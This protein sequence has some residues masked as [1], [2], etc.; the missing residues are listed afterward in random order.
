MAMII[1]IKGSREAPKSARSSMET[2]I[3]SAKEVDSWKTPPFQRPLR[4]NDKVRSMAEALKQNAVEISG[5][6]TLG[7][8]SKDPATWIVDGQHRLEAFKISGLEEIIADVRVCHFDS[9]GEMA[10]EFV[11]LNSSLVKMRPDD[12]LR[13]LESSILALQTIRKQ[14]DFVGYDNIRRANSHSPMLSM[15]ALLRCW[16][17]SAYETPTTSSAGL[18]A[19]QMAETIDALSTQNL[20]VF[21]LTAHSAWGRD[22][23]YFRLWGN[24]NLAMTM[25]MWR[26]FVMDKDRQGNKRYV[27]LTPAQFKQCLMSVSASSDYVDWLQGRNLSERDRSPCYTRLKSIFVKRLSTEGSQVKPKLPAPAWASK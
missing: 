10:S 16:M 2:I 4:I 19:A 3:V 22:P 14:C 9:M 21:L 11:Q 5:I 7:R 15:S 17:A 6:L 1:P 18:S 13:G 24:L 26:R 20:I 23:E 12:V 25:W 27:V 8:L